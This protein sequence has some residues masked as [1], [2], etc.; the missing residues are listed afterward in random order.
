MSRLDNPASLRDALRRIADNLWFS[1]LPDA[2]AVFG[3]LD[4]ARFDA[5]D[6]NP[7]ALLAELPDDRLGAALTTPGYADRV[8]RVLAEF[9]A[10]ASRPTAWQSRREDDR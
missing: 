10:E 6:H 5:L 3:E 4:P 8:E 9:D 7:T 2:R 1:W